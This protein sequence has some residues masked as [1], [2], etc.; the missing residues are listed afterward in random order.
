MRG[1]RCLP[2]TFLVTLLLCLLPFNDPKVADQELAQKHQSLRTDHADWLSVQTFNIRLDALEADDRNHFRFRVHRLAKFFN[3]SKPCLVGLQEP[4]SGQL[5]HL[6]S[7][8]KQNYEVIGWERNIDRSHHSRI[9]DYQTAI[10]YD[11]DKLML[12]ESDHYWLSEQPRVPQSKSWN[13]VG[14]RTVTIGA[15]RIRSR[16]RSSGADIVH[17]NTHLDVWGKLARDEQARVLLRAAKDWKKRYPEA[18]LVVTGDF[19][20]A[21]GQEPHKILTDGGFLQDTWD[22]CVGS[23]SCIVHHFSSTFHGWLGSTVDKYFA[24]LIQFVLHVI[25]GSG[26]VLPTEVRMPHYKEMISI[27]KGLNPVDLWN[28]RPA[29]IFRQHVDWILASPN[30]KVKMVYVGEV[31]DSE[32]SSDH[33]PVIALLE[34][35][36]V[37]NI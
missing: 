7:E 20:C 17:F 9:N 4:F 13:S 21:C 5:L 8:L 26:V 31:R 36:P 16:G 25:H 35:P 34:I 3:D 22:T 37:K 30:V 29:S 28:A 18:I 11:K 15:F 6:Q 32:F 2:V 23:E 1:S 14:I 24:R 12:V 27:L 10:M 33:F 19:N